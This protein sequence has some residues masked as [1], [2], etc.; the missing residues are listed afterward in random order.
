MPATYF[1]AKLAAYKAFVDNFS[2]L[3]T[4]APATYGLVAGD[5]V[6]I[7]ALVAALDAAYV[8]ST[9]NATRT[10]VTVNL[11]QVARNTL[12]ATL[13]GY[14][15]II[16]ANAGVSD[17]NKTALGLTI[18]DVHPTKIPA[19]GTAPVL[20]LTGATP[21]VLTNTFRDTGS[22]LKS[23]SKPAGVTALELHIF[24]GSVAPSSPDATPYFGL[25]TR[26][27]FAVNVPVGDIGKDAFMY[28]RWLNGKG[29]PGPWSALLTC[30]TI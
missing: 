7:A 30:G 19:P 5:A 3:V 6:S 23:R 17:A 15:R 18:R 4:A 2:A 27:P 14:A 1:P 29:E 11:T 28:G 10:P 12:S 24:F 9:S 16:L 13:R 8:T 21:G 26:S 22:S 25:F 20:A